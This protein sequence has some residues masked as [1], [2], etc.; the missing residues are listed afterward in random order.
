MLFPESWGIQEG[1]RAKEKKLLFSFI[2]FYSL[3]LK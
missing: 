2:V 1:G 3:I